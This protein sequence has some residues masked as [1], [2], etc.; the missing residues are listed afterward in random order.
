MSERGDK[1]LTIGLRADWG[2]GPFWVT[3]GDEGPDGYD[4]SEIADVVPL[5]ERLLAAV[6]EWN[7]RFQATFN[8][9]YPPDSSFA[10]PEAE[11]VFVADGRKLTERI[12]DE[13]PGGT[14]VRYG[15]LG[16]GEWEGV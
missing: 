13:A 5:S 14:V 2:I 9:E 8:A 16:G 6:T 4:T 12:K 15:A 7:E 3:I 11:A 1:Q 10:T